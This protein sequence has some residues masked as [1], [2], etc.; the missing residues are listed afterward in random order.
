MIT[1]SDPRVKCSYY[2][3]EDITGRTCRLVFCANTHDKASD[4]ALSFGES[5]HVRHLFGKEIQQDADGIH[6]SFDNFDCS[7]FY[8]ETEA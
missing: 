5:V 8:T 4:A 6:V 1:S 7:V 3:F 2:E